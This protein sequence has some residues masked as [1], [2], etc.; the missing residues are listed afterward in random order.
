[1]SNF[2]FSFF[3]S[4]L[5]LGGLQFHLSI[6]ICS[7]HMYRAAGIGAGDTVGNETKPSL[8]LISFHVHFCVVVRESGSD[9]DVV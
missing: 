4:V 9:Y 7:T 8:G 6:L 1:M 3:V 5:L 2:L